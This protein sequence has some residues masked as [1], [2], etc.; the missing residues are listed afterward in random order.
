VA[1][2]TFTADAD[3]FSAVAPQDKSAQFPG[4]DRSDQMKTGWASKILKI[5]AA[6]DDSEFKNFYFINLKNI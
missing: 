2:G 3:N 5:D 1:D 6:K 4:N